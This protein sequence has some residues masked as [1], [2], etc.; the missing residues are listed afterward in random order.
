MLGRETVALDEG[1][2]NGQGAL[3]ELGD[4]VARELV[5]EGVA[6][7][8]IGLGLRADDAGDGGEE[9]EEI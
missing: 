3:A 6:R 9:D 2:V 8:V 1:E 7:G 4:A 5:L